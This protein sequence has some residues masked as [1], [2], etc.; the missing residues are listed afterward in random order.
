ME[1]SFYSLF[2]K[3]RNH[4]SKFYNFFRMSIHTDFLIDRVTN[5]VLLVFL[6]FAKKLFFQKYINFS[7][8]LMFF[9][10]V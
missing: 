3:L 2:E 8:S 6:I 9:Y 10:F 5:S 1:G 4:D 7:P